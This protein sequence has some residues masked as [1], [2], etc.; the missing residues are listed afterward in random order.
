MSD[1]APGSSLPTRQLPVQKAILIQHK[2]ASMAE[3]RQPK[4]IKLESFTP[5]HFWG[6]REINGGVGFGGFK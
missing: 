5:R 4:Q 1:W 3:P 6:Q 2:Q